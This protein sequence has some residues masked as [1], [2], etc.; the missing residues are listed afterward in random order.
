MTRGPETRGL[1]PR[2]PLQCQL[3]QAG[4]ALVGSSSS[5]PTGKLAGSGRRPV[6][7]LTFL[8][9]VART[10]GVGDPRGDGRGCPRTA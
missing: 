10:Q 4:L 7:G 1:S 6:L 8:M 3:G 9:P 5:V 2:Q